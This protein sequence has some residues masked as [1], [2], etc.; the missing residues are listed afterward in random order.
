MALIQATCLSARLLGK[1][2]EGSDGG[3]GGGDGDGGR[4]KTDGVT[5]KGSRKVI[6]PCSHSQL[7]YW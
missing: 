7:V 1:G 2:E 4:G 6:D 3:G 5:D